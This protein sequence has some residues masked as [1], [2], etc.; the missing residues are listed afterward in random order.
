MN[1]EKSLK[2]KDIRCTRQRIAILRLM[3]E[4]QVPLSAKDIFSKLKASYPKLRLSTV[5]RNLHYFEDK[6]VVAKVDLNDKESMFELFEGDHHHHLV[7]VD[8]GKIIS[9]KCP[10]GDYEKRLQEET[11]YIVLKH[12][13]EIYGICPDCREE[14]ELED[15]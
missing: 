7:C 9:V 3:K 14:K 12:K 8:C 4:E 1:L 5:Y 13:L 6:K 15:K 11:G 2:E 10:L